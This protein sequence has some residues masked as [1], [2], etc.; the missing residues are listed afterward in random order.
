MCSLR[1]IEVCMVCS[2]GKC[3]WVEVNGSMYGLQFRLLCV[4]CGS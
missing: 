2:S 1:F 3:V 4:V